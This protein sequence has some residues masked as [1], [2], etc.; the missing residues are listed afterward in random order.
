MTTFRQGIVG[1]AMKHS[2]EQLKTYLQD[3]GDLESEIIDEWRDFDPVTKRVMYFA[4]AT[5]RDNIES[6]ESVDAS[7]VRF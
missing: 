2:R 5:P 1:E 3:I 6:C 7:T 4:M